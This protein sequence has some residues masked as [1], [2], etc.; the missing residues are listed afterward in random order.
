MA[1]TRLKSRKISLIKTCSIL[2]KRSRIIYVW[3][4]RKWPVN[5]GV[6]ICFL[7]YKLASSHPW[8]CTLFGRPG[9]KILRVECRRWCMSRGWSGHGS[10]GSVEDKGELKKMDQ[11]IRFFELEKKN[12]LCFMK[13]CYWKVQYKY[14]FYTDLVI[15]IGFFF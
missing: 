12:V 8:A 7:Q 9:C 5:C 6:S 13:F 4:E 2:T 14:F 10:V 3:W 15:S 11:N 1:E